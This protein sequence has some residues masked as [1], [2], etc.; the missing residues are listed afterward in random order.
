MSSTAIAFANVDVALKPAP[1]NPD[2]IL[3][4]NPVASNARMPSGSDRDGATFVWE[5][6]PG[7]FNWHYASS[8]TVYVLAGSVV[9]T[10][11]GCGPRE[12]RAGDVIAF[13]AG[14]SARWEITSTI[15]KVAFFSRTVPQPV[16]RLLSLLRVVKRLV[17][18][19]PATQANWA[20]MS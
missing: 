16:E 12:V 14:C 13:P 20:A 18:P 6:T 4:G 1:I 11:E 7:I 2:W 3:G 10:Q 19:S 9:I 5:C 17:R 15:R 8:E